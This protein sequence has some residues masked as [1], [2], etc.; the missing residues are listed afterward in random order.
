[1][2]IGIDLD[3]TI[4]IYHT[5]VRECA[6]A[7]NVPSKFKYKK[8]IADYLR[9]TGRESKW[10]E[11]QGLIY[12]PLMENAP[13]AA[14]FMNAL[15]KL[16]DKGIEIVIISHRTPFSE[17]DNLHDLHFFARI[18]VNKYIFDQFKSAE[19]QI[20]LILA[21]TIDDKINEIERSGVSYFIDDLP[22]ILLHEKF[23]PNVS[24]ILYSPENSF[25]VTKDYTIMNH[26][27]SLIKIINI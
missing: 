23:P 13:P 7:L 15:R 11:M 27:D 24:K 26:W 16:V 9:N 10:T 4:A 18:W 1:M 17:Y 8:E 14:G 3:N 21:K 12:G 5:T 2:K 6:H 20:S 25:S 19:N 22:K